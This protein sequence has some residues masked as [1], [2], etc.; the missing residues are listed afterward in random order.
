VP[1][2]GAHTTLRGEV[3]GDV[4]LR[5]TAALFGA[6]VR[7]LGERAGL[8][9][10]ALAKRAGVGVATLSALERGQRRRPYPA[11]LRRLARALSLAEAEQAEAHLRLESCAGFRCRL[12]MAG[13][14]RLRLQIRRCGTYG[15]ALFQSALPPRRGGWLRLAP[16]RDW[17]GR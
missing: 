9:Q 10:E 7:G 4:P 16:W 2:V 13:W 3:L 6:Q 15:C 12:T 8:S 17:L 5:R 11:S 14:V 1:P